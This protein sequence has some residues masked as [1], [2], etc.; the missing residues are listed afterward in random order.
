MTALLEPFLP[1]IAAIVV[2]L[3][4]GLYQRR[5]G[6]KSADLKNK[7]KERDSYE[8]HL[9][10]ISDAAYARPARSVSDDPHNRDR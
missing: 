9:R 2:V 1:Y 4:W 3:G 8:A 5:E 10:E 6:A 7:A